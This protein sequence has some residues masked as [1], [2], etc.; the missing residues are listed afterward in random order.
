MQ[1][2]GELLTVDRVRLGHMRGVANATRLQ[3]LARIKQWRDRLGDAPAPAVPG[4]VPTPT[5]AAEL[6]LRVVATPRSPSRGGLVRLVLGFGTELDAFATHAQLGANLP[7]PVQQARV[8]QLLG[9]L[10]EKWAADDDAR[11][12]LDR[13][14]EAASDRLT[15]LGRVATVGELTA[16]VLAALAPEPTDTRPG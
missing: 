12:L 5:D 1:T 15:E 14:A 10:Q 2:V 13:L 6:L 9:T 8:S 4:A 7:D 16:A 11:A 3:I